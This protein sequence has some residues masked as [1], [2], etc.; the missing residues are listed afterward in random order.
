MS[1]IEQNTY[2]EEVSE[3]VKWYNSYVMEGREDELN[4]M[5]I[6]AKLARLRHIIGL[7]KIPQTVEFV[8]EFLEDTDRKLVIFVHHQDVGEI[9]YS[10]L[11]EKYGQDMPV[12]KLVSSY[13]PQERFE[14]QEKFNNAP[15]ALMVA[16]T[17]AAGE[18]LNLQ[19]CADCILHER[20]WNP[21]NEEQAEGRFIRIGQLATSVSAI[22]AE[23]EGSVDYH[24]DGINE[25][26]RQAFHATMNKGVAPTWNQTEFAKELAT[27]IVTAHNK[28]VREK[29]NAA[30][31]LQF[32]LNKEKVS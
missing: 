12:L 3:F 16:S 29:A 28:K 32:N 30:K 5:N 17:L 9:I 2:D 13:G 6:L 8:D 11:N 10:Q 31:V 23:A 1:D 4:G 7:A 27:A 15:R 18:G 20:Q 26:K 14:I 21:A 19:T 24:L 25:R 22:Y